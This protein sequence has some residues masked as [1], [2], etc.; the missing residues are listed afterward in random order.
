MILRNEMP[1]PAVV[2]ADWGSEAVFGHRVFEG[3]HLNRVVVIPAMATECTAVL[4]M[5]SRFSEVVN[6]GCNQDT[7]CA[8]KRSAIT[9]FVRATGLDARIFIESLYLFDW[10]DSNWDGIRDLL[11][12]YRVPRKVRECTP[13][14]VGWYKARSRMPW[15]K[16]WGFQMVRHMCLYI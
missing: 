11:Y 4:C 3:D 15:R 6:P 9:T 1:W 13:H 16:A 12:L 5:I 2:S 10:P 14:P 7:E 8:N